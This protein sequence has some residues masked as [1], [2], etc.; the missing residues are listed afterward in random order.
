MGV[1]RSAA[2]EQC[3][4][5]PLSAAGT[6][7]I[8]EGV[9][10]PPSEGASDHFVRDCF[11]V[12]DL[13]ALTT[14][15]CARRWIGPEHVT[16]TSR[17]S[18][19]VG[20]LRLST[21]RSSLACPRGAPSSIHAS[22]NVNPGISRDCIDGSSPFCS[23]G[24]VPSAPTSRIRPSWKNPATRTSSLAITGLWSLPVLPPNLLDEMAPAPSES[25]LPVA[26]RA[27]PVRLSGWLRCAIAVLLLRSSAKTSP[28]QA[29]GRFARGF[30][31]SFESC[32]SCNGKRGTVASE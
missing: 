14:S 5:A 20:D 7:G 8:L 9:H 4:S 25:G 19:I 23:P 13:S 12:S 1:N 32:A 17:Q 30:W 26:L 22:L 24:R 10:E 27:V 16:L 18:R 2:K 15:P 21:F 29:A 31:Q 6:E 3:L 28:F 11:D